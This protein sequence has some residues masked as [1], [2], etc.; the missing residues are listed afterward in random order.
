MKR[1][2]ITLEYWDIDGIFDPASDDF[3]EWALA[4]PNGCYASEIIASFD[5]KEEA[6]AKLASYKCSYEKLENYNE[7]RFELYAVEEL[8]YD[9]D[10]DIEDYRF[11]QYA[12]IEI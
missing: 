6:L 1:Y 4:N 5:T 8:I 7:T 9:E 10:G 11:I 3:F 12:D 2:E